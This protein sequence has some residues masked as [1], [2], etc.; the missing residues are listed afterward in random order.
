MRN[1]FKMGLRGRMLKNRN[2]MM[3]LFSPPGALLSPLVHNNNFFK[4][5]AACLWYGVGHGLQIHGGHTTDTHP[6]SASAPSLDHP[7]TLES[8]E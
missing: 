6:A 7:L 1:Y 2:Y 3:R 8:E 4:A 5:L